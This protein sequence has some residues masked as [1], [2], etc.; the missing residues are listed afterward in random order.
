MVFCT[1]CIYQPSEK[2]VLEIIVLRRVQVRHSTAQDFPF[3]NINRNQGMS[4]LLTAAAAAGAIGIAGNYVDQNKKAMNKEKEMALSSPPPMFT[5]RYGT[6]AELG[7]MLHK[8]PIEQVIV[9]RD[10]SGVP[11]RWIVLQNGARYQTYD[12]EYP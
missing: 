5:G 9:D 3:L 11:F 10:L 6:V 2:Q 8:A 1:F 4:L 12:M 7:D